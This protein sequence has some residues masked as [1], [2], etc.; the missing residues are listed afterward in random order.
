MQIYKNNK[1]YEFFKKRYKMLKTSFMVF[2][3]EIKYPGTL[4]IVFWK[5]T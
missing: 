5:N 3:N 4:C 1:S 2:P